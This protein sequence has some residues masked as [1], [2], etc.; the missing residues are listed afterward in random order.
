MNSL[1]LNQSGIRISLIVIVT[2]L[3]LFSLSI[4]AQTDERVTVIGTFQPS[5]GSFDKINLSPDPIEVN[6]KPE[7][8]STTFIDQVLDTQ[9]EL[10]SIPPLNITPESKRKV[11]NN[12]LQAAIGSRLSPFFMYN[13]Y[14]PVGR[15]TRFGLGVRHFS[16]W[17]EMEDYAP[18]DFMQNRLQLHLDHGTR[19][20]TIG[21][22]AFYEYNV[23]HYY[24][25]KPKEHPNFQFV[26]SDISQQFTT[27]G[28][29]FK[30]NSNR[31][32]RHTLHHGLALDYYYLSDYYGSLEH[33]AVA[34]LNLQRDY[35]LIRGSD[36]KQSLALDADY[37]FYYNQDSVSGTNAEMKVGLVPA[38]VLDG[39][40]YYLKTG[41]G[42]DVG[43]GD[44]MHFYLY[45]AIHGKLFIL[46]SAVEVY[47]SFTG[48][49]QRNSY[50][51]LADENPFI[52]P[53]IPTHW[54]NERFNY[55][56][57]AKVALHRNLELH[58]G[59][60]YSFTEDKAFFV[61]APE[62][63]QQP[64][65]NQF[66]LVFDN[67]GLFQFLAEAAYR[68]DDAFGLHLT[69]K[70]NEFTMDQELHPWHKPAWEFSAKMDLSPFEKVGFEIDLMAAGNRYALTYVSNN[71]LTITEV[72][73]LPAYLDLNVGAN[74]Q[75]HDRL[76]TFV[77]LNN[78]LHNK[79]DKFLNYPVQGIQLFAGVTYS[80]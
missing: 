16:S 58:L 32:A 73:E 6:F 74:Y 44:S 75:F 19:R 71:N 2:C 25:F 37:A 60:R 50:R 22:E 55:Q 65:N 31:N 3:F 7:V 42:F 66:T 70:I 53:L 78:V 69:Y 40:Y 52:S 80:F 76:K 28:G 33:G 61:T 17:L 46:E 11:Q 36:S 8:E 51:S 5:I 12:F 23:N 34:G 68:F 20:H 38:F 15:N 27:L 39:N 21:F 1:K 49:L 77:S 41:I 67:T 72:H 14:S 54:E 43:I 29:A 59:V 18:S 79:Y 35:E 64:L 47:S 24:G 30:L 9:V 4:S 63:A 57:G 26:K 48:G 62:Q 10:E 13:H 56:G 45:P